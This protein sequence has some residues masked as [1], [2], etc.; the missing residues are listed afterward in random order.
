MKKT[1]RR[2]RCFT[3]SVRSLTPPL[4]KHRIHT[5]SR[6]IKHSLTSQSTES[7]SQHLLTLH[8]YSVVAD[9]VGIIAPHASPCSLLLGLESAQCCAERL[10][11]IAAEVI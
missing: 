7:K 6:E 1:D 10:D 11:V 3:H 8:A 9:S 2:V 5:V 4:N